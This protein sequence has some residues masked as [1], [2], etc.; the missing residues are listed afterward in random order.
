MQNISEFKIKSFL[1]DPMNRKHYAIWTIGSFLLSLCISPLFVFATS[2]PLVFFPLLGLFI[3][4]G[5]ALTL[6]FTS[7]RFLDLG[8]SPFWALTVIIPYIGFGVIIYL[9][10][11][12]KK[13]FANHVSKAKDLVNQP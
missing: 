8:L 7:R 12:N 3:L 5:L 4:G 6:V 9:C 2:A 1:V 10:F 13:E 11:V